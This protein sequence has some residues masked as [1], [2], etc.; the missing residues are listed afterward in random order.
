MIKQIVQNRHVGI[1]TVRLNRGS[2][3]ARGLVGWWP[4][5]DNS[6]YGTSRLHD[7]SGRRQTANATNWDVGTGYYDMRWEIRDNGAG[8]TSERRGRASVYF[9]QGHKFEVDSVRLRSLRLPMTVSC[10]CWT[11][12]GANSWNS[13]GTLVSLYR[14]DW[15]SP[16]EGAWKLFQRHVSGTTSKYTFG[17]YSTAGLSWAD[18]PT[19]TGGAW[20]HVV[21]TMG[22]TASSPLMT[23]TLNG[24]AGSTLTPSALATVGTDYNVFIGGGAVPHHGDYQ[25]KWWGGIADVRLWDRCLSDPEIRQLYA[26]TRSGELGSMA[27]QY[28]PIPRAAEAVET[29]AQSAPIFLATTQ[30]G[31]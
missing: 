18:S 23:T 24:V 19:F 15:A 11:V 25:G 16:K 2:R 12:G 26:E 4:F 17:T 5:A 7:Y 29:T 13:D 30:A 31:L 21:A 22:G 20:N 8:V 6:S 14:D 9:G 10:W 27:D 28:R 3:L 1:G